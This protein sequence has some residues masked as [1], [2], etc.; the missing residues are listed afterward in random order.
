MGVIVRDLR[1]E[2]RAAVE[3]ALST[4]GAFSAEEVRVALE[5]VDGGLN[6]DYSLLAVEQDGQ[7]RGYACAG[8]AHLTAGSWYLYWIC[9]HRQAQGAGL[10]RILQARVEDL[11]RA[12]GGDRLIL[13]TSGRADY[14][15]SRRF[16]RTAGFTEAGRIPD[17]YKPGDDCLVYCK[18]LTGRTS[19]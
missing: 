11:V 16:Y 5:M 3:D 1:A 8:R 2:D 4:C 6:G 9:V 7:V 13:E 15:R 19:G 17:F 10:G 14:E 18:V 12:L